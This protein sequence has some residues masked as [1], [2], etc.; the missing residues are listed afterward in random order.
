MQQI[1]KHTDLWFN[2]GEWNH[3]I[4]CMTAFFTVQRVGQP[5]V[6][7]KDQQFINIAAK[8]IVFY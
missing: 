4:K 2:H 1:L 3:K 6:A 7:D 5:R 8:G